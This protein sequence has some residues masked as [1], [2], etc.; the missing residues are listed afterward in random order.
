MTRPLIYREADTEGN[1]TP[2]RV[3]FRKKSNVNN[4]WQTLAYQAF[5]AIYLNRVD[6]GLD[7][8]K[9]IWEKGY[10]EGFPWDMDHWGWE[11]NHIYMTHP[12]MWAVLNALSGA[13]YNGFEKALIISPRLIPNRSKLEIPLFFPDFWLMMNYIEKT[14]EITFRVIKAFESKLRIKKIIHQHPDGKEVVHKLPNRIRIKKD[15]TFSVVLE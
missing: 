12:V 1:E 7:I 11:K 8:I 10:Y 3:L 6:D 9:K 4:P 15:I 14:G 5:E 2:V 13:S